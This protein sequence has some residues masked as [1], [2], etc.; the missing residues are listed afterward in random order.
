MIKTL[1]TIVAVLA[2]AGCRDGGGGG[3]GD[4]AAGTTTSGATGSAAPA[5]SMAQPSPQAAVTALLKAE[6]VADHAA[7]FHFLSSSDGEALD[8]PTWARRRSEIPAITAFQVESVDG[9]TVVTLVEHEPG[10]DPFLGLRAGRERQTW[11]TRRQGGGWL[12]D[13]QPVVEPLYPPTEQAAGAALAWA[14]AVLACDQGAATGQEGV[15]VLFGRPEAAAG[16]CG[17]A[18][19]LTAGLPRAAPPGPDTTDLVAQFGPETLSWAK[20]VE[21]TGGVRPFSVVLAPIGSVWKVV[22]VLG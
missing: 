5:G 13:P 2:L 20:A 3:G 21:I 6:Q 17:T 4:V 14:R 18:V 9:P 10:L 22:A 12:V 16:L 1:S 11:R 8:E 15:E 19:T 7:S